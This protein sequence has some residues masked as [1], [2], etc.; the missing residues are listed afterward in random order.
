MGRGVLPEELAGG[1]TYSNGSS[2]RIK[3]EEDLTAD[4]NFS[5]LLSLY[6]QPI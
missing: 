5:R 6:V 4:Y 2:D 3:E 1:Y